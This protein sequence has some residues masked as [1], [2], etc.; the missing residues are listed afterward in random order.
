MLAYNRVN[1]YIP[2]CF[3][4]DESLTNWRA[5]QIYKHLQAA[6]E[7]F[8]EC[9]AVFLEREPLLATEMETLF[10]AGSKVYHK[11]RDRAKL[12]TTAASSVPI[13]LTGKKPTRSDVIGRWAKFPKKDCRLTGPQPQPEFD[14]PEENP[15]LPQYLVHEQKKAR[16]EIRVQGTQ[17]DDV[18]ILDEEPPVKP[19]AP[20]LGKST[21][22]PSA[23]SRAP[24]LPSLTVSLPLHSTSADKPGTSSKSSLGSS[25]VQ[26]SQPVVRPKRKA[27]KQSIMEE[28]QMD[29]EDKDPGYQPD[30]DEEEIDQPEEAEDQPGVSLSQAESISQGIPQLPK[31]RKVAKEENLKYPC[32]VC[33]RRFQRTSELRDH[34]Y[35]VHLGQTFDCAECLKSYQTKKAYK[36]HEK[37][38]HQGLRKIKCTQEGC[39]WADADSGKLHNHLLSAH[40]IGEPIV[41]NVVLENG[42]TCGKIFTNTRSFQT[43][44]EFHMEKKYQCDQCD[45]YF[46][47][48]L[49]RKAHIHKY[50]KSQSGEDKWQC[51]I[52]GK[53]FDQQSLLKNHKTLHM[54]KHHR[55]LQAQKKLEAA[56]KAEEEAAEGQQGGEGLDTETSATT[57]AESQAE[58]QASTSAAEVPIVGSSS[59]AEAPTVGSSSAAE[60][61]PILG[62]AVIIKKQ[63]G[64]EDADLEEVLSYL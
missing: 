40:N 11:L 47:T 42:K 64:E 46:S 4:S 21:A 50:H 24:R 39:D 54:L 19:A 25:Q 31:K 62:S 8:H 22:A 7:F 56:R 61:P 14:N 45:R 20:S 58:P 10:V 49:R 23:P 33:N 59:A 26:S 55:E 41:C 28:G 48:E 15:A 34:T 2:T 13:V 9:R 3:L 37:L 18:I 35:V 52:C 16:Q 44:A 60:V 5:A 38:K 51:D 53:V 57:D 63:K 32:K 12:G 29:D 30:P 17:T 1:H 27:V 36:N 43:H 6:N